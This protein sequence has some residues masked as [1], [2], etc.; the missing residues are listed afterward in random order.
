[1]TETTNGNEGH[2]TNSITYPDWHTPS[3]HLKNICYF[4]SPPHSDTVYSFLSLPSS[5]KA[6][7]PQSYLPRYRALYRLLL[8][9]FLLSCFFLLSQYGCGYFER[10]LKNATP[11][12][13]SDGL[14]V[15]WEHQIVRG[16]EGN[17]IA[18]VASEGMGHIVSKGDHCSKRQMDT[19]MHR[20]KMAELPCP[21]ELMVDAMKKAEH[22]RGQTDGSEKE[23]MGKY[24]SGHEDGERYLLFRLQAGLNNALMSIE[25][26]APIAAMLNRTL[27][28]PYLSSSHV[29]KG[30]GS[31]MAV[32]EFVHPNTKRPGGAVGNSSYS[33]VPHI[34]VD[35]IK[36]RNYPK[37]SSELTK[38]AFS[39]YFSLIQTE[40]SKDVQWAFS[41]LPSK[42]KRNTDGLANAKKMGYKQVKVVFMEDDPG[43][44]ASRTFDCL[45]PQSG[46][47]SVPDEYWKEKDFQVLS[48]ADEFMCMGFSFYV[49]SAMK[50]GFDPHPV[51]NELIVFSEVIESV[52]DSIMA[53]SGL[54]AG[55]Y[56]GM[57][58]RRGD[59]KHYCGWKTAKL[60]P[61]EKAKCY[62]SY[63]RMIQKYSQ[64]IQNNTVRSQVMM[65][66][67]SNMDNYCPLKVNISSKQSPRV[68][69]TEGIGSG[70]NK[71]PNN[72]SFEATIPDTLPV[73]AASN[74]QDK[75][76]KD[77]I[78]SYLRWK[79][80][81]EVIPDKDKGKCA[82]KENIGKGEG[83][84]DWPFLRLLV[85]MALLSRSGV[86]IANEFSSLSKRARRVQVLRDAKASIGFF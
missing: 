83:V 50:D 34:H 84:V 62:P 68:L 29:P 45:R 69:Y 42:D 55:R 4:S 82:L 16:G 32:L 22:R 38:I 76:I 13:G 73:Y 59:F 43:F 18:G 30:P 21:E 52:T 23:G 78:S 44:W 77:L 81:D 80:L 19:W 17:D 33:K 7:S 9:L 66:G 1:M 48:S 79:V 20:P 11:L 56:V 36:Y 60:S 37:G 49:T 39:T 74:E 8:V 14:G 25:N 10:Q 71:S 61:D 2:M 51:M 86:M 54:E 28:I 5:G 26:A 24:P 75:H 3:S 67:E 57:H 85:D 64:F 31:E 12:R 6:I 35:R 72:T 41:N 47:K 15:H 70:S 27:V 46:K 63:A 40:P 58:I 65:P 53:K